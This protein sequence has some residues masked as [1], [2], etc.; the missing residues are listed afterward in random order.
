MVELTKGDLLATDTEALI[1]AVNTVGVMGKGIALQFK[2]AFPE[3]YEAYKKACD[4]GGVKPGHMFIVDLKTLTNP[5]Y[6]INFPT[7]RHWKEKS[8]LVDI[9]IGLVALVEDV[10][11]L[12]IKSVAVPPLGCGLGG[13]SWNQVYS[14]MKEAFAKAPDVEWLVFE[15]SDSPRFT[16]N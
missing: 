5:Y 7:K 16:R 9:K 1:N 11:A 3:N 2:K 10:K 13:L 12:C 8:K 15:P 4:G 6:I 14:L